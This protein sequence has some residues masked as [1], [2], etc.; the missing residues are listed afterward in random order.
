MASLGKEISVTTENQVGTLFKVTA[1]LK[2]TG[3]SIRGVCAWGDAGKANFLIV[4]ENNEKAS[5][6]LKKAGYAPKEM[7]VVLTDLANKI[8]SLAEAA[9]KLSNAGVD[10]DHCYVTA[11]G[12]QA[13]AVFATK[14][15][16]KAMKVL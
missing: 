3:V 5:Q 14:D 2:E 12:P 13:L 11:S 1:P 10:I 7:E 4:T 6:A 16:A 8:G 9:Q 15:N